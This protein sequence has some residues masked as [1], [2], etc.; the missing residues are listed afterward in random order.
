M[1]SEERLQRQYVMPSNAVR[2]SLPSMGAL[3]CRYNFSYDGL[4]EGNRYAIKRVAPVIK[5]EPD[6]IV[7]VTVYT[8]FF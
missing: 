6:E 7:V 4:W 3:L 1:A 8:F 5:E 2:V